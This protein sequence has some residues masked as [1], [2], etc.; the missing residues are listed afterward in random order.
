MPF[1]RNSREVLHDY[2]FIKVVKDSFKE[3]ESNENFERIAI[4]HIGAVA[5]VPILENGNLVLIKQYRSTINSLSLEAVAGR[6]DVDNEDLEDCAKRELIE[7]IAIKAE[8]IIPLGWIHTSPGFT[9]ERIYLFL[10]LECTKLE[11]NDP[12]G[13]EEKLAETIEVSPEDAL[14]WIENGTVTDGKSIININRAIKYLK[15][16]DRFLNS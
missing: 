2:S 13:I 9:D 6:R 14:E 12:D 1:S 4:E 11:K 5:V 8:K 15:S 10:G 16:Q 7:E 3:I